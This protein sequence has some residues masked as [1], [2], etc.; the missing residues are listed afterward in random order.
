MPVSQAS[1]MHPLAQLDGPNDR[2]A[3]SPS[4]CRPSVVPRDPPAALALFESFIEADASWFER[5]DDSDGC[6]GDAVRA[7]CRRWLEAA[8]L[9][10]TPANVWPS[11]CWP[12]PLHDPDVQVRAVLSSQTLVCDPGEVRAGDYAFDVGTAGSCTLVLQT[13]LPAL[14]LSAERGPAQEA[15][16][17]CFARALPSAAATRELAALARALGWSSD[18]PAVRQNEGP[19][20]ALTATPAYAHV[21]EGCRP[22]LPRARDRVGL[23]PMEP[24]CLRRNGA[25]CSRS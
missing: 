25:S 14:M 9:C 18:H 24:T 2:Q 19:G 1:V 20:N 16:P 17:E 21:G 15:Y 22:A 3:S 6:I 7:T 5:A 11:G 10:E 4:I 8:A 13:V 12:R 23:H